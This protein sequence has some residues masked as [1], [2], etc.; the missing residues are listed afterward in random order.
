MLYFGVL[1]GS[2]GHFFVIFWC[3]G[4]VLGSFVC[5]ILMSWRVL[6]RVWRPGGSLGC[7]SGQTW[8]VTRLAWTTFGT[9][10]GNFSMKK[11]LMFCVVFMYA[12]LDAFFGYC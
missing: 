11:W 10:L 2:W 1:K 3:L 5:D 12:F 7:Q 6:G 9:V 8:S 4:G